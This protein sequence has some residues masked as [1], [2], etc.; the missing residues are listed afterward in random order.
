MPPIS[1]D[2][3][4]GPYKI[5]NVLPKGKGGMARVHVGELEMPGKGVQRVALKVAKVVAPSPSKKTSSE[6]SFYYEALSNE[7]EM[8]K[9]LRHPNIVR[10]Y[11]IP[12]A[13]GMRR[14]PYIAKATNVEGAPWFCAMEYLEGGSLRDWV[15]KQKKLSIEEAVEIAYQIGLALDYIHSEET[16]HLDV[17][18]DNV[19]FRHTPSEGAPLEPVLIDFGIA[20]RRYKTGLDAGA[21]SYMA[22]ERLRLARGEIAPEQVPDQR[23][24]DVYS[25]GI[26]LYRMLTGQLPF[27]GES[28]ESITSAVL[29]HS[30]TRPSHYNSQIPS[31]L[32]T[33]ILQTLEKDPRQRPVV[34]DLIRM[35]DEA[36]PPP[37]WLPRVA[38]V[39]KE[40]PTKSRG[41]KCLIVGAQLS[42]LVVISMVVGAL[43]GPRFTWLSHLTP[44]PGRTAPPVIIT[45]I[46]NPTAGPSATNAPPVHTPTRTDTPVPPTT[47]PTRTPIR[48]PT[49]M[50]TVTSTHMPIRTPTRMPTVTPTH[51][52][53]RPP[54]ASPTTVQQPTQPTQLQLISPAQGKELRNPITFGWSGSLNAGE[55]Y[56]VRAYHPDSG[57]TLQSDLLTAQ[58]WATDLP[59]DRYG[60]WR[61]TVS[62]I[63]EGSA[64]ATSPEWMFWFN[65]LPSQ[66]TTEPGPQPSPTFTPPPP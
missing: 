8:L 43:L 16:A 48:T 35:L 65:P 40:S 32:E 47:T 64:V 22:P 14:D 30:P 19:L 56:Q 59:N 60:E 18:P 1:V 28:K 54:T 7:V 24:V 42:L 36:V 66:P 10:I 57:H 41:G 62:V 63:R 51:T 25:L 11:P 2:S 50:P 3:R 46:P 61:W 44:T 5:A 4:V 12:W 15:R 55:M 45:D 20:R 29:K 27:E 21:I 53:T 38:S 52:P 33:I 6:Q 26:L 9:R 34:K 58:D 39:P 23:P 31:H 13:R 37:R 49:R 17:K